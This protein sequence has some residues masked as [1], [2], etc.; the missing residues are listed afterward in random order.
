MTFYHYSDMDK[1]QGQ[2]EEDLI[3]ILFTANY[4]YKVMNCNVKEL[5]EQAGAELGQAQVE[6]CWANI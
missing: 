6:L 3:K 5:K 2:G 1:G 4:D